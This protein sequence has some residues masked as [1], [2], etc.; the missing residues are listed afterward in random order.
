MLSESSEKVCRG[1]YKVRSEYAAGKLLA[2]IVISNRA[3]VNEKFRYHI[4]R[5]F[6]VAGPRQMPNGGFVLP[7]FVIAALTG[8]PLTVFGTGR[9]RR[10]FTDVRDIC[11]AIVEIAASD[12]K[13]EEWNIGNPKNEMSIFDLAVRVVNAVG[14]SY[15]IN[16]VNP[17]LIHGE[18][19]EEALDKVPYTKKIEELLGWKA[20]I[21][22]DRTISDTI[23]F[24]REKID[25]GYHFDM[26]I[27]D[28][29]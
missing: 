2:E 7:R 11:D 22:I 9:Q 28:G 23:D 14:K 15:A 26:R 29:I 17:K 19:F 12:H 21:P 25:L 13:N 3:K 20:Q 6:N 24:Y 4:I 18:L 27:R 16:Q 5:P 1:E 10:A 8:Q